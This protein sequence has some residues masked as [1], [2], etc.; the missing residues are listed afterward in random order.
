MN[1]DSVVKTFTVRATSDVMARFERFLAL[2]HYNSCSGHSCL[3]AMH[4]DGDG[5]ERLDVKEV[6]RNLMHEVDAIGDVGYNVE[7]A[8]NKKYYGVFIDHEK[9]A[10][11]YT[12]N[13][14]NLYK[15]GKVVKTIPSADH[16]HSEGASPVVEDPEPEHARACSQQGG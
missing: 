13:A 1:N 3:F 12:G 11:W 6:D 5:S 10:P 2:L 14:A 15:D 8:G 9:G 7:I 4:L 16:G